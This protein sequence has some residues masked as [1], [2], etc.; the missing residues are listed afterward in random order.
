MI[1]MPTDLLLDLRDTFNTR[2]ND[3]GLNELALALGVDYENLAGN[4]KSAKA[5]EF[6]LHIWRHSLLN[7]LARV[8]PNRRP[9]IDWIGIL[10]EHPVF[11]SK[12]SPTNKNALNPKVSLRLKHTDL[13]RL[14]SI[15]ADRPMFATPDGRKT[16]LALAGVQSYVTVDLNGGTQQVA[17]SVLVQLD[18]Y[19]VTP[20]SESAL[21]LLLAYLI[22][23]LSLPVSQKSLIKEI[24]NQY[25][26]S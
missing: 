3:D 23:D 21:G 15:L 13:Q 9:D 11:P 1:Q 10:A 7:E 6:A 18:E 17:G 8:G 16:L 24:I 26:L 12:E 22:T 25:R 14:V 5:R 19:G 2:F 20:D 4:S